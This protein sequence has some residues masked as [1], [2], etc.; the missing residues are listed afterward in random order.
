MPLDRIESLTFYE[1]TGP[2]GIM[3]SEPNA[4]AP[5]T[6]DANIGKIFPVYNVFE[7][8]AGI[9]NVLPVS[10]S[11]HARVTAFAFKMNMAGQSR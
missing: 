10:I 11:N 1:T 5:E 4:L 2:R 7:A 6:T 9:L 3:D 8:I